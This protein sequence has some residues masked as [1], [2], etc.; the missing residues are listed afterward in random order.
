MKKLTQHVRACSLAIELARARLQ[1]PRRGG[2]HEAVRLVSTGQH[3]A[4]AAAG[5]THA[6]ARGVTRHGT[7][8]ALVRPPC[9]SY[10]P[11]RPLGVA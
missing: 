2:V 5:L 9:R 1:Q 3:D 7:L 6:C 4:P 11:P 8:V 10:A